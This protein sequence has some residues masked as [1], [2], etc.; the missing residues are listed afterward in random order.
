MQCKLSLLL[1]DDDRKLPRRLQDAGETQG[2]RNNCLVRQRHET[3]KL[4]WSQAGSLCAVL[5]TVAF[6]RALRLFSAMMA[7]T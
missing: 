4:N 5:C 1:Y 3:E 2:E 6:V 7:T